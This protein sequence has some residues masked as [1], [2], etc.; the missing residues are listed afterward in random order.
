MTSP[1]LTSVLQTLV[2]AVDLVFMVQTL[3]IVAG[4]DAYF[5]T[6]L[7][8]RIQADI[9]LALSMPEIRTPTSRDNLDTPA[10]LPAVIPPT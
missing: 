2:K 1:E 4:F 7:K 3:A 8:P 9:A 5:E 6:Q 10:E